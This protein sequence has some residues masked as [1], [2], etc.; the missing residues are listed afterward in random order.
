VNIIKTAKEE[1]MPQKTVKKSTAKPVASKKAP[2]KKVTKATKL[3]APEMHDC[4]CHHANCTC[5]HS[6]CA[7]GCHGSKFGRVLKKII[8]FLVIFAL[9]WIAANAFSGG[10]PARHRGPRMHY[11][12]GCLDVASVKCPK[13]AAALPAMDINGDGCITRDEARAVKRHMRA[14]IR[15]MQVQEVETNDAPNAAPV[16][17]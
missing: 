15:D 13:L 10:C 12:N 6:G 9:G 11:V 1:T 17:E 14:E 3:V 2:V 5:G 7:C 4:G 16:A 8:I